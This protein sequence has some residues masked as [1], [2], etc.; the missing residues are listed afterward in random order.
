MGIELTSQDRGDSSP[1]F[2][3]AALPDARPFKQTAGRYKPFTLAQPLPEY[4]KNIDAEIRDAV[5]KVALSDQS[6]RVVDEVAFRRAPT[7]HLLEV[8]RYLEPEAREKFVEDILA[9][10]LRSKHACRYVQSMLA[11]PV[12]LASSGERAAML[13]YLYSQPKSRE[14]VDLMVCVLRM[15]KNLRQLHA[16]INAFSFELVED[17]R[18]E[19]V[20]E[21]AAA[22][23]LLSALRDLQFPKRATSLTSRQEVNARLKTLRNILG[24]AKQELGTLEHYAHTD[25]ANGLTQIIDKSLEYIR[26]E[27]KKTRGEEE[28]R[29]LYNIVLR[30]A[31]VELHY[32]L[33]LLAR[34]G[35]DGELASPWTDEEIR[36]LDR[37]LEKVPRM[38]FR[39]E[40]DAIEKRR[41]FR[42]N[43]DMG[44]WSD[45]VIQL[46]EQS[47][48]DK[49][50][51]KEFDLKRAI[52]PAVFHEIS[53]Y[54]QMGGKSVE[55]FDFGDGTDIV[56]A[57]EGPT[58]ALFPWQEFLDLSGWVAMNKRRCHLIDNNQA[59]V[60]EEKRYNLNKEI[61]LNGR[62]HRFVYDQECDVLYCKRI[63]SESSARVYG[64][65]S[66]FEAAAEAITF[67]RLNPE[68]L[69]RD[70]PKIFR[71]LE[72][73]YRIYEG[74]QAMQ[75]KL[76]ER[77]HELYP[78]ERHEI[79]IMP[80][81]S[82][83]LHGRVALEARKVAP[84]SAI[85]R[86]EEGLSVWHPGAYQY[87][88]APG[89]SRAEFLC[90]RFER[91]RVEEQIEV[92]TRLQKKLTTEMAGLAPGIVSSLD[93]SGR[94]TLFEQQ[95]RSAAGA[96]YASTLVE[97]CC[98][99]YN[100]AILTLIGRYL[101][102]DEIGILTRRGDRAANTP[103]VRAV[104]E[105]LGFPITTQ[106][107]LNDQSL[108][109]RLRKSGVSG[110]EDLNAQILGEFVLGRYANIR[111]ESRELTP[112]TAVRFLESDAHMVE[113]LRGMSRDMGWGRRLKVVNTAELSHRR[114]W[115]DVVQCLNASASAA[116]SG[117]TF[118]SLDGALVNV[119]AFVYV[120]DKGTQEAVAWFTPEEWNVVR[121]KD[122]W[123][124]MI[125]H[126]RPD[127][128]LDALVVDT[129]DF[130]RIDH[131]LEQ[132]KVPEIF[133]KRSMQGDRPLGR[134]AGVA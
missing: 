92:L 48:T 110:T 8:V 77:L 122:I 131:V 41:K 26:E 64:D 91:F 79:F 22:A 28:R 27:S 123:R 112:Y 98:Q 124:E 133:L 117:I 62:R 114:G 56:G 25:F 107:F 35:R 109:V 12:S 30:K 53:H 103:L 49:S 99:R 86:S 93:A 126:K 55:K 67:Y 36:D 120:R 76:S 31:R 68:A 11:C 19:R 129:E 32:G 118:S 15:S 21:Y 75:S 13:D 61:N 88:T 43:S 105:H 42:E 132:V 101:S 51:N 128:D 97:R 127:L 66:P 52:E 44:Y 81:Q 125:K 82:G 38:L 119:E 20:S 9:S 74:E 90:S 23:K 94:L 16:V 134:V 63:K 65:N 39:P 2:E 108:N 84:N 14:Q 17:M 111:G 29:E 116:S 121:V 113:Q 80:A 71:L 50:Y 4:I 115:R 60:I 33:K 40:F 6:P 10:G 59:V 130:N 78:R 7:I 54:L 47:F 73:V 1:E 87:K 45:G 104:E 69:I 100:P 58:D 3:G 72:C 70:A 85:D 37:V 18:S 106:Y 34:K 83:S 95:V 57:I 89:M 24:D 5:H 102:G 96:Q 46:A